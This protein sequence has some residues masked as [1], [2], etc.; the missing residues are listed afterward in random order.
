MKEERKG[1][2]KISGWVGYGLLIYSIIN[3][4]VVLVDM[5]IHAIGIFITAESEGE[6]DYLLDRYLLESSES[7]TSMIV[8]V[9]LGTLF[10]WLWFRNKVGMKDIF[11]TRR[12]MT[13][14]DFLKL[15]SVFMG[16][17]L[18]FGFVFELLEWG[19]NLLGYTAVAGIESAT[20]TSTTLS[21]FLYASF[22]GPVIEEIVDRGFV[23][24]SM[25]KY[26]KLLAILFSSVMFGI[27]HANLPQNVFAFAVGLILAY[28]AVE[29]SI[30]WSI[31]LHIINNFVFADLFSMIIQNLN[32]DTQNIIQGCVMGTFFIAAIVILWTHRR[33]IVAY[34]RENAIPGKRYLYAFTAVGMILYIVAETLWA[35]RMLEPL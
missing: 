8:G 27:S 21:M 32:E 19:L 17:Q 33:A 5:A 11:Q 6:Y 3:I 26:G 18:L 28:V 35:L 22:I 16:G 20:A 1:I 10:L 30:L 7:A 25:E 4:A 2:K 34:I 29:Y 12:K 13:S 9:I 23:L 14:K 15:L 24:R 31:A